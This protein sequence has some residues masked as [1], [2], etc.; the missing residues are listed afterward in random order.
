V[1]LRGAIYPVDLDLTIRGI[2]NPG[3]FP[4]CLL[5][6]WSYVENAVSWA[7]GRAHT[8]YM[9]TTSPS[10]AAETA[11]AIDSRF[12]NSVQPTKTQSQK[13]FQVSFVSMLGNVKAFIIDVVGAVLFAIT[14]ITAN[15][16]AMSTRE[17][18]RQYAV[19]QTL[20]FAKS[21]VV[22]LIVGEGV[23]M[24]VIGGAI[25]IVIAIVIVSAIKGTPQG[26]LLLSRAEMTP[27]IM[28]GD[29]TATVIVGLLS[30]AVPARGAVRHLITDGIRQL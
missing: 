5:F 13:A 11:A 16:M 25:G 23:L 26:S 9:L 28:A 20:G 12:M 18:V 4:Q 3:D 10:V 22:S 15:T 24:A 21:R 7:N 30:A 17:K 1:L 14:L 29:L 19:M 6:D 27:L 2:F 8:Y